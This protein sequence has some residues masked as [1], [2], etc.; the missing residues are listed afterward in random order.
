MTTKL[1]RDEDEALELV[2]SHG[3]RRTLA[4][5]AINR[6]RAMGVLTVYSVVDALTRLSQEI[7]NAGERTDAD[8]AA[9][10]LLELVA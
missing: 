2:M 4:K 10:S 9:S 1:E 5:R 3:V 8:I 7:P 6:A